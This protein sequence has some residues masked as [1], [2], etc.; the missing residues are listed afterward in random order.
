MIDVLIKLGLSDKEAKVYLAA[1]ELGG[2]TA[3]N[4]AKKSGVN[5][6]T[7]Y[8][9]AEKLMGLGLLSRT[10]K[11]KKTLFIPESPHELHN[12]LDEQKRDIEQRAAYLDDSLNQFLAIF[13]GS[14]EKPTVR[15][16]EGLDGLTALDRYG[17]DQFKKNSEIVGIFPID[18]V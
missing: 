10:D 1:L 17:R 8:V 2:D 7:T 18:I 3:Q 14:S 6:A 4:I 13:N 15:Y 12:L 5:R 9:I 11:A 16:F